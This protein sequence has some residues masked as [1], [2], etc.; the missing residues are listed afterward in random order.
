VVGVGWNPW[1]VLRERPHLELAWAL[2]S[3]GKGRIEDKAAGGR[4]ITIDARLDRRNRSATLGHELV[5]DELNLLW[6]PGTPA[7]IVEKG[8]Q[9]VERVNT[10]RTIPMGALQGFVDRAV[11]MGEGVTAEMVAEEFDTT[12]RLADLALRLLAQDPRRDR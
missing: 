1:R 10:G 9:L 12:V 7:G 11:E 8:E 6:P 3:A 5:H 4:R 2:L